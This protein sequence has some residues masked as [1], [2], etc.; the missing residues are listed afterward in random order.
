LLTAGHV[1]A[2][3][4]AKKHC[5]YLIVINNDD[6]YIVNKKGVVPIPA[7]QRIDILKSI[8]Y[9]DEVQTYSGPNEHFWLEKFKIKELVERFGKDSRLIIFH[10]SYIYSQ[11]FI[12]GCNIADEIIYIPD[13]DC[14]SVSKIF[15]NIRGKDDNRH[16]GG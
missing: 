15:E 5:D 13:F 12:P 2:L 4:F 11:N 10:A 8:K 6:K 16:K 14:V 1:K 7:E 3:E 9:I